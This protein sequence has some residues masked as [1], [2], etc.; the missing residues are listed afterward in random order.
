[1]IIDPDPDH[2]MRLVRVRVHGQDNNETIIN[3][4]KS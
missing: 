4:N 2:Q 3:L 1:M